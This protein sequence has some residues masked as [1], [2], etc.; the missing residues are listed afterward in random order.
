MVTRLSG[1]IICPPHQDQD[2][3]I[4]DFVVMCPSNFAIK[5]IVIRRL[6]IIYLLCM[7]AKLDVS[8]T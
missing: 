2:N 3:L 8:D 1:A 5:N 4:Y 7:Q 6:A